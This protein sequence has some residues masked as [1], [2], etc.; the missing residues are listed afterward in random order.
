MQT[1]T[2]HPEL[3]THVRVI[4]GT[5]LA[6]S[7]AR[8]LNGLAR[9]IQNP[10]RDQIYGVHLGWVLFLLLSV[11]HFWWFEFGLSRIEVWTFPI[12]FFVIGYAILFFFI[13]A[14][15]FPDQMQDYSGFAEYFE[16]RKK[17]FYG[18]LSSL[19]VIDVIDTALKGSEYFASLGFLYPYKQAS[20]F[21]FA[22][23]AIFINDRRYHTGFVVAALIIQVWFI[24][25]E[26]EFLK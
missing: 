2:L 24:L 8:L 5:V 11:V 1:V 20:L 3:F 25:A 6:L 23:A 9:F 14:I 15:L 18:F 17:W 16:S 4:I 7:V 10:Q 13:C 21:A 22:I 26:F 19:F 12:Y